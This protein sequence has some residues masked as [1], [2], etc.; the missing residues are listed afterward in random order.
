MM[1]PTPAAV[2]PGAETF[3]GG[4]SEAYLNINSIPP[5][6]CYLDGRPLGNTPKVHISVK[7]GMHS[8]KF[9]NAEQSLEKVI[10]VSVTAGET[11]PAV[12]KLN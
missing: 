1:P 9:V 6:T 12:A 10:S 8:V 4:G 7:P 3:G 5:S 2:N 11:K